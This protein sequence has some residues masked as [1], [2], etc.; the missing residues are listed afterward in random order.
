MSVFVRKTSSA[1]AANPVSPSRLM[2]FGP[3]EAVT[4]AGTPEARASRTT[5]GAGKRLSTKHAGEVGMLEI[6]HQLFTLCAVANDG[7]FEI[8]DSM[9]QQMAFDFG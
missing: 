6:L 5:L 4:T 1:G 3:P 7:D 8:G 2:N 9:S